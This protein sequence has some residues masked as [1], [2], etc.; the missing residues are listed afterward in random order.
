MVPPMSKVRTRRYDACRGSARQRGYTRTWEKA[1]HLF[2][3]ERPWCRMCMQ[4]DKITSATVVDHIVPHR[5][6]PG[7]FW[8]PDNWQSLCQ[9]HHNSEKQRLERLGYVPG[10]DASGR[11]KD[12]HH[13]WNVQRRPE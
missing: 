10:T 2:L 4:E 1:R 9:H 12:K 6:D 13:P 11:P 7:L 3:M 8:S 5:G